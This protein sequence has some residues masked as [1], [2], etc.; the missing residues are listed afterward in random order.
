V[1]H[2]SG[3]D[4]YKKELDFLDYEVHSEDRA[5]TLLSPEDRG[6]GTLAS[7]GCLC[8]IA[9]TPAVGGY[10]AHRPGHAKAALLCSQR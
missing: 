9:E 6:D 10:P 5:G 8:F 2:C 1:F 3:C 7:K 4:G